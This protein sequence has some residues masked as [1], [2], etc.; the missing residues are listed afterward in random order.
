MPFSLQNQSSITY[1]L[2]NPDHTTAARMA[3][4]INARFGGIA[5]AKDFASVE[6]RLPQGASGSNM[7]KFI[8]DV[9]SLPINPDVKARVVIN[10]RTGTVV[11]GEDVRISTV[12][13]AKG[14]LTIETTSVMEVSQPQPFSQGVT[15]VVEQTGVAA[16][17][18]ESSIGSVH[19]LE[20]G[21]SIGEV[22][23]ALNAVGATPRD[24]IAIL[25]AIKDAGALQAELIV[26]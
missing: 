9:E 11:I 8:S 6:V 21:V 26:Q 19:M 2:A 25:H 12:A 16:T 24:L 17:E 20:E 14:N 5:M 22:V 18:T 4:T 1:V 13:I 23:R 7:V 15:T 10:E 3:E